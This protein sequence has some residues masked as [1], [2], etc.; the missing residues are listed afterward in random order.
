MGFHEGDQ[1][2][3]WT[4]GMGQIV[5]LEERNLSGAAMLY[6]AVQVRDMTVWVPADNKLKT[7]LRP[8]TK[9]A[10][11]KR[12]LAILSSPGNPLP[13]DRHE[14]KTHLQEMQQ[15]GRTESLCHIIR[16]L[17]AYQK[18]KTLNDNDHMVLKQSRSSLL[19]EWSY[20]FSITPAQA[21]T[22]LH[23]ALASESHEKKDK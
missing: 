17:S 22:E 9:E 21:E 7:R 1:V 12:L 16:D 19:G 2:M 6:Y 11:F 5:R 23:H 14:R 13:E 20:V 15:D 18:V 10:E 3:H 4:Y 8:P